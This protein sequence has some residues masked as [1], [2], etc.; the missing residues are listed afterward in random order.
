[1]TTKISNIT[2]LDNVLSIKNFI[3]SN[4]EVDLSNQLSFDVIESNMKD[5]LSKKLLSN[6]YEYSLCD[7]T[8]SNESLIRNSI[9]ATTGFSS[10]FLLSNLAAFSEGYSFYIY[11]SL[12]IFFPAILMSTFF[13]M[14]NPFRKNNNKLPEKYYNLDIDYIL[15]L[16]S[17]ELKIFI[18][19]DPVLKK[20]IEKNNNIIYS[21]YMIDKICD[22]NNSY[23][24]MFDEVNLS[25]NSVFDYYSDY[26]TFKIKDIIFEEQKKVKDINIKCII[27][28]KMALLK[29]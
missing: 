1:M 27:K 15:P 24:K 4:K 20:Y 29:T 7:T 18:N 23:R 21:Q 26:D 10:F 22:K 12:S 3:D 8:S 16:S 13:F 19:N 5:F 6:L 28:L 14:K 11:A 2:N 9:G 25:I 17:Y